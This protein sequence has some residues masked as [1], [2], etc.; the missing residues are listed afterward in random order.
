MKL[1]IDRVFCENVK[2]FLAALSYIIYPPLG[3]SICIVFLIMGVMRRNTMQILLP[4]IF[5][6]VNTVPGQ[7]NLLG[8]VT[9][10][11]IL[12]F[13]TFLFLCARKRNVGKKILRLGISQPLFIIGNGVILFLCVSSA[14]GIRIF[15][16]L[17][18]LTVSIYILVT[19]EASFRKLLEAILV[20]SNQIVYLGLME[21][22]LQRTFFYSG[23]TGEERYRNGILR[24]GSTVS[25]PNY[26][27]M[28]LVPVILTAFYLYHHTGAG[29][30]M[31]YLLAYV[32]ICVLT[33]S[34]TGILC[35]C[36]AFYFIIRKYYFEKFNRFGRLILNLGAALVILMMIPAALSRIIGTTS[37]AL[38]AS[39][40]TRTV[41]LRYGLKLFW[42]YRWAGIGLNSFYDYAQPWFYAEYGGFFA[43]G[44]TVM[45]MPLE[46]GLTFGIMGAAA[47][48][49]FFWNFRKQ[50]AQAKRKQKRGVFPSPEMLLCFMAM[51]MTLDGMTMGLLWIILSLPGTICGMRLSKCE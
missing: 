14:G 35:L 37:S 22:A 24:I 44:I 40:F 6:A 45:N 41:C 15:L 47:F 2:Y 36:L 30:Y 33:M 31:R 16:A 38:R 12:T 42:Q 1:R 43:E 50:Y 32:G 8:T 48:V 25:D 23:W 7:Y 18:F 29:R 49:L 5:L 13:L 21:L 4:E 17:F 20:A 19:D 9:H 26:I 11:Q 27:C 39:N 34:R 28:M 46:I 3:L 51:S 10:F